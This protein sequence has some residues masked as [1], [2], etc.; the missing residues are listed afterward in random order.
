ML[1][2]IAKYAWG[3]SSTY[4]GQSKE[5]QIDIIE[6]YCKYSPSN[7]E[8][9]WK[10]C[11]DNTLDHCGENASNC[12]FLRNK[13]IPIDK[14]LI[15]RHAKRLERHASQKKSAKNLVDEN[16][17]LRSQLKNALEICEELKNTLRLRDKENACFKDLVKRLQKQ[18]V[19]A[20]EESASSTNSTNS[21]DSA[22]IQTRSLLSSPYPDLYAVY[23]ESGISNH[24][25]ALSLD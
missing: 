23:D 20:R 18:L 11:R 3:Q 13:G 14:E 1:S 19:Q 17:E 6:R 2:N 10:C 21:S 5:E 12:N 4:N 24:M 22:D 7:D 15:I 25:A 9:F 8:C 16:E